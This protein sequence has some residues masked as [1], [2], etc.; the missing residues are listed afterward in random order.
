MSV[1]I[2]NHLGAVT[3]AAASASS[4]SSSSSSDTTVPS[5]ENQSHPL[6]ASQPHRSVKDKD[7]DSGLSG[8]ERRNLRRNGT[9]LLSLK[10]KTHE[11]FN[12]ASMSMAAFSSRSSSSSSMYSNKDHSN[13]INSAGGRN[14]LA[15]TTKSV[16]VSS[17]IN[18]STYNTTEKKRKEPSSSSATGMFFNDVTAAN[19]ITD[20]DKR[21][22]TIATKSN[23]SKKQRR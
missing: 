6:G 12:S 15:P 17:T 10:G 11:P 1:K 7:R 18:V 5:S 2:L 20:V 4:S 23:I 16:S 13:G 22:G 14:S 9:P 21:M 8:K 19:S 3:V